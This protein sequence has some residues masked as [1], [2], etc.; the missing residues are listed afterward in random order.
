MSSWIS[1]GVAAFEVFWGFSAKVTALPC[2]YGF[3]DLGPLFQNAGIEQVTLQ[4]ITQCN[5]PATVLQHTAMHLQ[6]TCNTPA[7]HCK[8]SA[9]YLQLS[10]YRAGDIATCHTLQHTCNTPETHSKTP[11]T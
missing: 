6:C 4:R 7:T 11:A 9:T 2:H 1:E 10:W 3:D 8:T 5:T